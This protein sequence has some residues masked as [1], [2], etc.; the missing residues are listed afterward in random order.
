MPISIDCYSCQASFTVPDE[1][2]GR[3][4]RCKNC[5]APFRIPGSAVA[6]ESAMLSSVKLS[7]GVGR[8]LSQASVAEML[9]ELRR[10]GRH[11]VLA[12]VD[13]TPY[14]VESLADLIDS[15]ERVTEGLDCFPTEELDN[16]H[17]FALLGTL[18]EAFQRLAD[19]S[20]G[21]E[22]DSYYEPFELKGDK[23]GMSL[24]EFKSKYAREIPGHSQ[25]A[26]FCSD[27]APGQRIPEL[28]AEPWHSG[29]GIVHA[30]PD[31]PF[32]HNPPTLAGAKTDLLLY[33][34][35]DGKLYQITSLL[36][37]D[38]HPLVA[39][40]L[41]KKFGSPTRDIE[42]GRRLV[43]SRIA[44]T[45]ELTRGSMRPPAPSCLRVFVDESVAEAEGRKKHTGADI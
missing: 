39:E 34:F 20:K 29:A 45:I 35:L 37:I 41:R 18:A 23:L 14:N 31:H 6:G 8:L 27:I 26:P 11:G 36:P 32:E 24:S 28:Y 3:R 21:A 33:Q 40:G 38:S 30:R 16:D 5:G 17:G 43:W 42:N 13:L 25:R 12:L 10:R 15:G 1:Y 19:P 44:T 7:E 2:A 4:A 22:A 9:G